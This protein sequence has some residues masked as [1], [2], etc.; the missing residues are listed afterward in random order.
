MK[1]KTT[2]AH[3]AGKL[4]KCNAPRVKPNIDG[5]KTWKPNY[6]IPCVQNNAVVPMEKQMYLNR[7][8]IFEIGL[9]RITLDNICVA[10]EHGRISA[11]SIVAYI[12]GSHLYANLY[13]DQQTELNTK[14]LKIMKDNKLGLCIFSNSN[15]GNSSSNSE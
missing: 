13:E 7:Q 8:Q 3:V 15:N 14:V 9:R 12:I 5:E 2:Y 4:V 11:S 1:N 6:E 10:L